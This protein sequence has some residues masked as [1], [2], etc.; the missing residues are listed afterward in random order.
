[1]KR[2]LMGMEAIGKGYA[3]PAVEIYCFANGKIAEIWMARNHVSIY[4]QLG[5]AA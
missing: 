4:Q 5:L 3:I 1:M 2:K